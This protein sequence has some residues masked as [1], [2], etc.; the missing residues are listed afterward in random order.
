MEYKGDKKCDLIII[1]V[2]FTV[3]CILSIVGIILFS[4]GIYILIDDGNM[5]TYIILIFVG[6]ILCTIFPLMFIIYL[7][8]E[9]KL[10]NV[11]QMKGI[12]YNDIEIE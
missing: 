5:S 12:M 4:V 8:K 10:F 9:R 6:G 1:I 7:W 11:E 3:I 2:V